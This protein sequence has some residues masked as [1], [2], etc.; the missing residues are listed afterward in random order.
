MAMHFGGLKSASLQHA[1]AI[2]AGPHSGF[3]VLGLGF[4]GR[5]ELSTHKQGERDV[6]I[7]VYLI[8]V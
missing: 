6:G 5:Q 7:R 1:D 2:L 4:F 8:R 3:W